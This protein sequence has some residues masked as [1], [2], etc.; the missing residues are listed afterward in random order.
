M[1]SM[2]MGWNEILRQN[3]SKGPE[4]FIGMKDGWDETR[5]QMDGA[6]LDDP[7]EERRRK[8]ASQRREGGGSGGGGM[9]ENPGAAREPNRGTTG[10]STPG[11]RRVPS[12]ARTNRRDRPS[13]EEDSD[14]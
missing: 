10:R 1:S 7:E 2:G 12:G 8:A 3:F 5:E 11:G 6:S 13:V 9:R 14:E 4:A